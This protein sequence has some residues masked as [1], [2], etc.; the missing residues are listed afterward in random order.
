MIEPRD[1][2]NKCVVV[3]DY[4]K[5]LSAFREAELLKEY[6]SLTR[7]DWTGSS[8][9]PVMMRTDTW[10]KVGGLSEEFSP[11][12]Y[13]DPDL[14][15]KVWQLGVRYFR[16][17]GSSLVY[18]FQ[19]KSTGRIKPNN[20]R[21]TFMKKWGISPSFFYKEYLRM[22]QPWSGPLTYPD[23]IKEKINRMRVSLQTLLK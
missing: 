3:A 10:K 13:S 23:S 19:S 20:G 2:G 5:E 21:L 11:G 8:W 1:T 9:P 15:M 4:G 22:G 18:H 7:E 17:V 14:A 6:K 12:M 16:G